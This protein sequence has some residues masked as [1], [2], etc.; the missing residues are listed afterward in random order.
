MNLPS[1]QKAV[2]NEIPRDLRLSVAHTSD[3]A[4]YLEFQECLSYLKFTIGPDSGNI[5]SISV[6][7]GKIRPLSGDFAVMC[8]EAHD[9]YPMPGAAHNASLAAQDGVLAP[10]DYYLAVYPMGNADVDIAFQ[11]DKGRIA[12]ESAS[13][14]D[15][16]AGQTIDMGTVQD[17]VFES[18]DIIPGSATLLYMNADAR[19]LDLS[20]ISEDEVEVNVLE[21]ADWLSVIRAKVVSSS[22][23]RLT[24]TENSG[25]TRIGRFEVVSQ[26]NGS[27]ILYTVIQLGKSGGVSEDAL[28]GS[29]TTFYESTGGDQ[30]RNNSGWC[31]EQPLDQWYGVHFTQYGSLYNLS[32]SNNSLTGILPENFEGLKSAQYLSL[33]RNSLS[34]HIYPYIYDVVSVDLRQNLFL[35]IADVYDPQ[36]QLVTDGFASLYSYPAKIILVDS[37]GKVVL[38]PTRTDRDDILAFLEEKYGLY[39]GP[40]LPGPPVEDSE[41][42]FV[43]VLQTAE[44]GNGI[45]LVLMGDS[46]GAAAINDG[47]YAAVMREAMDY[48]FEIEPY[49]SY[50]HLFN[51]YMVNVVSDEGSRLGVS[52]G[53]GTS[54]TGDD[55]LCF[56]YASK[57]LSPER[58]ADAL[59]IT[60]VNST[61]FGGSTYMYAP[62]EGDRGNGKAV[63]YIPKVQKKM[64]FRGLIQHEAGGHGFAK[65]ADEYVGG[66]GDEIPESEGVYEGALDYSAGVWRPTYTSIMKDNQGVF[67][68]PSREA[69]WRR[70][71]KLA[72]GADW[73]YDFES[74]AEYDAAN[75]RPIEY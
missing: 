54:I 73:Q 34:G 74:F 39:D 43:T 27:R 23:F 37:D 47:T 10:G 63:S 68:A 16:V 46:Y 7:G 42:G 38:D 25:V 40:V 17:L 64:D 32:L 30:W 18:R 48:F 72:Y 28:R 9:V 8:M 15:C 14:Y 57:A 67:N 49:Q 53:E 66:L 29:L 50:R 13:V 20:L 2:Q 58:L 22:V 52:Y 36:W 19:S 5:R 60:I 62:S 24:M 35:S 11:D 45:D 31:S 4:R 51:V 12:L 70:I 75:R 65:L 33:S 59:V 6:V 69:I 55:D 41:D 61:Q 44:V 56:Q 26:D 1:V 21:G 71:H 3:I